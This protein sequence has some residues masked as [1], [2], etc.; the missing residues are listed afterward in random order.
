M[1]FWHFKGYLQRFQ[2][3]NQYSLLIKMI[4]N[5]SNNTIII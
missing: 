4:D 3:T 2:R 5:S 1:N